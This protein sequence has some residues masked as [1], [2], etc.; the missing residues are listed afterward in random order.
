MSLVVQEFF[1]EFMNQDAPAAAFMK[2]IT[3]Q[4]WAYS[5]EAMVTKRD[6]Y[7]GPGFVSYDA[8]AMSAFIDGRVVTERIKCPVRVELQGSISRGMLVLDRTN[9][10]KK[11]HSV[12]I[13]TKCDVTR[14]G[15]LLKMSLRQ[16]CKK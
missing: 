6:V 1:E 15:E 12:F 4:C 13:F 10:L 7:F 5:K 14:F 3:S 11:K 2:T 9:Q 16:P 8:Y